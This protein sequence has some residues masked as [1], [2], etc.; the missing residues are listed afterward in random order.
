MVQATRFPVAATWCAQIET[1]SCQITLLLS[2]FSYRPIARFTPMTNTRLQE[3]C[4]DCRAPEDG[5][6]RIPHSYNID[7]KR[8]ERSLA[9]SSFY[10][11]HHLAAL[12]I[13]EVM[14]LQNAVP[15]QR[16]L[17][18][19][20]RSELHQHPPA[21][22]P[23][24]H[25]ADVSQRPSL[26]THTLLSSEGGLSQ[27]C[28]SSIHSGRFRIQLYTGQQGPPEDQQSLS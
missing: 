25:E 24:F 14:H 28:F 17:L 9:G 10:N 15:V 22:P 1:P 3:S 4:K 19:T 16:L 23:N 8:Q 27:T 5:T 20:F 18:R 7:I 6:C 12:G 21:R 11:C 13:V 2:P 26:S